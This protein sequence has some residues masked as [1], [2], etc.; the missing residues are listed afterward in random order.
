MMTE[1][2][3]EVKVDDDG[4]QVDISNVSLEEATDIVQEWVN[5]IGGSIR[6]DYHRL[7]LAW[8]RPNPWNPNSQD[9]FMYAHQQEV[10]RQTGQIAPIIV[11]EVGPD[12]EP[13][14]GQHEEEHYQI[15]DGE[16]RWRAAGDLG[17]NEIS[18]NNLGVVPDTVAQMVTVIMNHVRG[19]SDPLSLG[20]L[21]KGMREEAA[22]NRDKLDRMARWMPFRDRDIDV[23]VDA[24][25]EDK[26]TPEILSRLR[27]TKDF[28]SFKFRVPKDAAVVC[29][30]A[31]ETVI[32][33]GNCT[34][35]RA[36]ELICAEYLSGAEADLEGYEEEPL[37]F[38]NDSDK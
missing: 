3:Q 26:K 31:L 14:Q 29:T 28:V 2:Y 37:E 24:V 27:H 12:N 25:R 13:G 21:F 23:L 10:M 20:R 35:D 38:D 15:V 18:V 19:E 9:E 36:F 33:T 30:R 17:W 11:R 22:G 6:D 16:H 7:E 8:V 32:A 34:T 4:G 1:E 5:S